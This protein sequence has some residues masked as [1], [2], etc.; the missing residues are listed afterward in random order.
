MGIQWGTDRF[1]SVK[2]R[3]PDE[4]LRSNWRVLGTRGPICKIWNMGADW[5]QQWGGGHGVNGLIWRSA[6][7][8]RL[9]PLWRASVPKITRLTEMSLDVAVSL[10]LLLSSHYISLCKSQ[11][12][13]C[14]GFTML[15][16]PNVKILSLFTHT[17][18][19]IKP[20]SLNT[21]TP[22]VVLPNKWILLYFWPLIYDNNVP[23]ESFVR[24]HPSFHPTRCTI[25]VIKRMTCSL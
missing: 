23:L 15:A 7:A 10:S 16:D 4:A 5:W 22:P 20:E 6:W 17:N 18:V 9:S 21:V 14:E 25:Y 24:W 8:R 3:L 11:H 19:I 2:D 1:W 12:K 13:H